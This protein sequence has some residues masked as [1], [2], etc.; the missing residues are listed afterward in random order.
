[1][2]KY[3]DYVAKV[4]FDDESEIFHGEVANL[5]DVITFQGKSV[6][7]LK[8]AF[9]DSVED[10][11]DFCKKRGEAPEKPFSGNFPVRATPEEHQIFYL[12]AM[13]SHKSMNL[14]VRETLKKAA[15]G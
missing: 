10:Y 2:M 8:K 5:K 4:E 15:N 9:K 13:R 14:W 1:M 7:E 11:L 3:K 12:A 6:A